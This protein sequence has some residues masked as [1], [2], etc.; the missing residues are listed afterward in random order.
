M[1]GERLPASA[2]QFR[3]HALGARVAAASVLEENG[4]LRR[5][6]LSFDGRGRAAIEA[7]GDAEL[8]FEEISEHTFA[9]G[10]ASSHETFVEL[11]V[12]VIMDDVSVLGTAGT[13]RAWS[14]IVNPGPPRSFVVRA[15]PYPQSS[16]GLVFSVADVARGQ[17]KQDDMPDAYSYLTS[18]LRRGYG[19]GPRCVAP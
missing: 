14:V 16:G 18:E 6:D 2:S 11:L 12:G 9:A 17:G 3:R 1:H 10:G 7:T 5:L 4:R 15:H 13:N 8:R 19:Y